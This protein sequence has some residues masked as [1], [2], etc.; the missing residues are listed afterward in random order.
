MFTVESYTQTYPGLTTTSSKTGSQGILSTRGRPGDPGHT[1]AQRINIEEVE[2]RILSSIT[3]T[4]KDIGPRQP[5]P[6]LVEFWKL[7]TTQSIKVFDFPTGTSTTSSRFWPGNLPPGRLTFLSG[8][9]RT[10][11][12]PCLKRECH[13][14]LDTISFA[15]VGDFTWSITSDLV[16]SYVTSEM[17]Y[18]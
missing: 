4:P 1:L 13:A 5:E 10:W 15:G 16:I 18:T 7:T 3:L 9:L 2:R 17:M 12:Q 11:G 14:L 6:S 8:F